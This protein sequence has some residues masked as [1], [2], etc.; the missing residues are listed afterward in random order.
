MMRLSEVEKKDTLIYYYEMVVK[1]LLVGVGDI[2]H[3]PQ[4]EC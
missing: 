3:L 1:L 4:L 2:L